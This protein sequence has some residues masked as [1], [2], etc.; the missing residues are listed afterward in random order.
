MGDLKEELTCP[1]C[2]EL[3]TCPIQLPCHHNLCRRCAEDVLHPETDSS[4]DDGEV[5]ALS[6]AGAPSP[7]DTPDTFPC[8]ICHDEV[9]LDG[10][11]LDGLKKDLLLQ[12]I[13]DRYVAQKKKD[14]KIPCQLCKRPAKMAAKSCLECKVSYCEQ[15]LAVTHPNHAPFTEHELVDPRTTFDEVS[16]A[17]FLATPQ[18][19]S[20]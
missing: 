11:G 19:R 13:V 15:C 17:S 12:H 6:A 8:P 18:E 7:E 16:I 2:L 9:S 1:V 3:F 14:E 10:R 5:A 4:R 20:L